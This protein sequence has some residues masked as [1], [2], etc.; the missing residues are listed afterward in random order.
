MACE[1]IS[2]SL[3]QPPNAKLVVLMGWYNKFWGSQKIGPYSVE[4]PAR[5]YA[6]ACM[7]TPTL[8]EFWGPK[9]MGPYSV[10][11]PAQLCA[12]ACMDTPTLQY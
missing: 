11:Q 10:E 3:S 9:K 1:M 6:R 5:L 4:Q 12:R 2:F 8:Q 7:D